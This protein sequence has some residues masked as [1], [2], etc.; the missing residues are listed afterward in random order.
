M[1]FGYRG[2]C[3]EI[4]EAVVV[5]LN[6][7]DMEQIL[8]GRIYHGLAALAGNQELG[9]PFHLPRLERSYWKPINDWRA[10]PSYVQ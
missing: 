4:G 10:L 3:Q 5:L 1:V 7:S 2:M 8:D 6:F 9:E